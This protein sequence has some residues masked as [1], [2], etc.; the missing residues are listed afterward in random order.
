MELDLGWLLHKTFA[1][2]LMVK[3]IS[4]VSI[5]KEVNF[6]LDSNYQIMNQY[7]LKLQF[8]RTSSI[9]GSLIC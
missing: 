1:I 7:P 2:N 6:L 5:M 8:S 4:Q 9:D 3:L